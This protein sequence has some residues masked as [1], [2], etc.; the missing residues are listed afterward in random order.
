MLVS[1]K[2]QVH[3]TFHKHRNI[4]QIFYIL[5]QVLVC[6]GKS[7][8]SNHANANYLNIDMDLA[9]DHVKTTLCHD[10]TTYD[11]SWQPYIV[12]HTLHNTVL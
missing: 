9:H 10:I 3:V 7:Q 2:L 5:C 4:G 6:S 1:G 8:L 12:V 11:I